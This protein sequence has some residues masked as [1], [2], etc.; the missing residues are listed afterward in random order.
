[1]EARAFKALLHFIY[2]DSLPEI[3]EG[4]MVVVGSWLNICLLQRTAMATDGFSHLTKSCPSVLNELLAK[5]VN[6]FSAPPP[7]SPPAPP[8]PPPQT[9]KTKPQATMTSLGPCH[10]LSLDLCLHLSHARCLH[11]SIAPCLH[12]FLDPS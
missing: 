12:L 2:T 1:M 11:L 8:P 5:Q 9:K 4:D 7:P 10:L 3:D 6:L